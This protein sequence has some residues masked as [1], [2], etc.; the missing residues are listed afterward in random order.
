MELAG[1]VEGGDRLATLAF[2]VELLAKLSLGDPGS[3]AGVTTEAV[4][5][6][7]AGE[8]VTA[9]GVDGVGETDPALA[10]ARGVR[11]DGAAAGFT[12]DD[13]TG[14]L[15]TTGAGARVGVG[16]EAGAGVEAAAGTGDRAGAGAGAATGGGVAVTETRLAGAGLLAGTG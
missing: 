10:A 11:G 2:L 14:G 13:E 8:L 1:S 5:G 12:K 7:G 6:A 9:L 16:V 4:T 3:E 15:T